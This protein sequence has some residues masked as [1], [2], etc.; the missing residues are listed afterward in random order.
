ME[1]LLVLSNLDRVI[2]WRAR[3]PIHGV[4]INHAGG[5]RNVGIFSGFSGAGST[6]LSQA[7]LAAE[8]RAV[9]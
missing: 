3:S 5:G 6:A 2:P 4:M 9:F 7:S 1:K 8:F